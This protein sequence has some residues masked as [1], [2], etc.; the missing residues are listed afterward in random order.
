MRIPW[1][2]WRTRFDP[3]TQ[4]WKRFWT[5]ARGACGRRP[6]ARALG[7]GGIAR[8]VEATGMSRNTVRAGLSEL[9][10]GAAAAVSA[11]A[12]RTRRPG[13]GRKRL[14]DHDPGLVTA[15]ELH[16]EPATRGDPERPLR[17]TSLSARRLADA[18]SA[19]GHPVSERTVN[20]L[21][22]SLGYSLQ[23]NRKTV[24]GRRHPDRDAQFPAH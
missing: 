3:S 11:P 10:H 5:S 8:V 9:D 1:M 23:S 17:W 24:E 18:L 2:V 4:R 16:L 6:E 19:E 13:G 20:R 15:L 7:R 22:H 21:L 14:S 12:G